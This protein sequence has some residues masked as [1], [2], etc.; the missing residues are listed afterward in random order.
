M[1]S[2]PAPARA[3]H[4]SDRP[5]RRSESWGPQRLPDTGVTARPCV[6]IVDDHEDTREMYAWCMRAAGWFVE[7]VKDG[8]EALV[9]APGLGPD[10]IVMDLRL[11]VVGGLDAIRRLKSDEDTR[12]ILIVACTGFDRGTSETEAWAAGCDEF[13]AKPCEPEVLRDLLEALVAG[14][15]GSLA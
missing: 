15:T 6:L 10:V 13:I 11:P 2:P 5:P 14:G 3:A 1:R 7:A 12:D 9:F 8:A 4:K